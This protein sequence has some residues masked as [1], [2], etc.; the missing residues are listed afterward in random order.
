VIEWSKLRQ[1]QRL[2]LQGKPLGGV[3]VFLSEDERRIIEVCFG[4]EIIQIGSAV[5]K[6]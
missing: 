2:Y 5:M 6:I 4:E 1:T 3:T